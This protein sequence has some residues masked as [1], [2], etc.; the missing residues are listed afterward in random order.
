MLNLG[1]GKTRKAFLQKSAFFMG[2][3]GF[4]LWQIIYF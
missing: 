3:C 1:M 4:E 2:L